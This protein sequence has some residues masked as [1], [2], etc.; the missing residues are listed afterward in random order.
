[1]MLKEKQSKLGCIIFKNQIFTDSRGGF[2]ELYNKSH[3]DGLGFNPYQV[4]QSVSK[5]NVVRGLHYQLNKPQAKLVRVLSGKVIDVVLDLRE[6]SPTYGQIETFELTTESISVLIPAG[7]AHGFWS[8]ADDTIFHYLVDQPYNPRGDSGI[9]PLD[10]TLDL[11]WQDK[12]VM[13]SD[14][15]RILPMMRDFDVSVWRSN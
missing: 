2:S 11:P 3:L 6:N 7:M 13:L 1:M 14:K 8:L 5:L 9:N 10:P 4:N 15:D 12:D